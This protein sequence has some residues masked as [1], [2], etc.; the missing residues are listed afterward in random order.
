VLGAGAAAGVLELLLDD[1]AADEDGSPPDELPLDEEEDEDSAELL[2]PFVD[3]DD[4]VSALAASV[5][6]SPSLLAEPVLFL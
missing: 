1:A 6:G 3:S 2:V 4:E 5:P